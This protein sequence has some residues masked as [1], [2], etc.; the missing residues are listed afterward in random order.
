MGDSVWYVC[1]FVCAHSKALMEK[2][3]DVSHGCSDIMPHHSSTPANQLLASH[4]ARKH[5]GARESCR[6]DSQ[7]TTQVEALLLSLS[8]IFGMLHQLMLHKQSCKFTLLV[9]KCETPRSRGACK[10]CICLESSIAVPVVDGGYN[11][12]LIAY[13]WRCP[14]SLQK[15]HLGKRHV[16]QQ[17]AMPVTNAFVASI[18][19]FER[20]TMTHHHALEL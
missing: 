2:G 7:F 5:L 17:S 6:S 16:A 8:R 9:S 3:A 12:Q 19:Y 18:H 13:P 15:V 20:A 10:R 4:L 14:S 11:L 1:H